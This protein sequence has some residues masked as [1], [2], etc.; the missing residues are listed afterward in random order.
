MKVGEYCKRG[1]SALDVKADLVEAAQAMRDDHVGFLV[2][3]D[4]GDDLRKPVGVLTDRDIVLQIT[5]REVNPRTV[6]VGDVMTCKPLIAA[7]TD[8]LDELLQAMRMAGIRRV[9]V[10]DSRGA[11]TGIIAIDDVIGVMNR[12]LGD[13]SGAIRHEQRHEW[14]TRPAPANAS[15]EM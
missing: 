4:K 3:F 10:V 8:E 7:E 13:I 9:P 12:M 14:R 2:V 5:A 6:T 15:V 1:V 11:L